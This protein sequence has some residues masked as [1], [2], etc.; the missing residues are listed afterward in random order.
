MKHCGS[1][2]RLLV[3]V[4]VVASATCMLSNQF[5]HRMNGQS[6]HALEGDQA[7]HHQLHLTS[8]QEKQ[9]E[10]M[11]QHFMTRKTE[12]EAKIKQANAELGQALLADKKYSDKVKVALDRIHATQ[13]ELQKATLEHLFEMQTVLTPEQTEN[14]NR[15]AAAALINNP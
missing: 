10:P 5:W 13:G 15:L 11:E 3:L 6:Q 4:A 9:L 12:L 14:L 1:T 8:A 7:L 2:V